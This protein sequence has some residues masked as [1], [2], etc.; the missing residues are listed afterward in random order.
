MYPLCIRLSACKASREVLWGF[1]TETQRCRTVLP[2]LHWYQF[3][4]LTIIILG[5]PIWKT[6]SQVS[7][8]LDGSVF[9]WAGQSIQIWWDKIHLLI[10]LWWS[11]G[12]QSVCHSLRNSFIGLWILPP[13]GIFP[14]TWQV[15]YRYGFA[16]QYIFGFGSPLVEVEHTRLVCRRL[17][18]ESWE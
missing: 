5:S 16:K 11:G 8:Q 15:R 6:K 18:F 9:G 7:S 12:S 1:F 4:F 17:K 14:P 10:W 2:S 3:Q 13:T